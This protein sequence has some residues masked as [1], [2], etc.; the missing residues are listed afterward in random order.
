MRMIETEAQ[1]Q[2][3]VI[4]FFRHALP[5]ET[6]YFAVP[7]GE[8]RTKKTGARLKKQGV[9]PGVADIIIV[10]EGRIIGLELKTKK[11]RQSAE[12]VE[13]AKRLTK[14]GGA[15]YIARSLAEVELVLAA[16]HI[17][18]KARVAA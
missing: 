12:Q 15:Y 2:A 6:V 18:V 11:G 8:Y 10:H 9:M 3:N 13:F 17:G 1:L 16:E 7:N 4:T 14:A 5:D